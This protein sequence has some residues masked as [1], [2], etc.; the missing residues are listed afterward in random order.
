MTST[1]QTPHEAELRAISDTFLSQL[2]ALAALEERKRST[3]L[4]DPDLPRLARQVVDATQAL[5][6][7][8][9]EQHRTATSLHAE[10]VQ[11]GT[12]VT[13]EEVPADWSAAQILAMWRDTERA[14]AQVTPGSPRERE[15]T[16]RSAAY[17]LAYQRV[18]DA[19]RRS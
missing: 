19:A 2:D 7:R 17:R 10:A 11:D 4:D 15:L 8:A 5:L 13:I 1:D 18:H 9:G 14:L 6:Q 16:Q 3:P 12:S